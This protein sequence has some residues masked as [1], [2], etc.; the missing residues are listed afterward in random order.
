MTWTKERAVKYKNEFIAQTYDRVNLTLPKGL[1]EK[2]KARA[3]ANGESLNGYINRLIAE[4]MGEKLD[5]NGK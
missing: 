4:D 1:K 5:K 3:E 2:A